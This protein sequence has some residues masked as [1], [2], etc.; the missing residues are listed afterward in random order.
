MNW[1]RQGAASNVMMG[2]FVDD[3]DGKTPET[4]LTIASAGGI[5][6]LA[7]GFSP[8][9]F[10]NGLNWYA[11]VWGNDD[12]EVDRVGGMALDVI[13]TAP[14]KAAHPPIVY[15]SGLL[16]VGPPGAVAG[17]S[18]SIAQYHYSRRRV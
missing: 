7:K 17:L 11:P 10:L 5:D 3:T 16:S 1:L 14:A 15:P 2:P 12:P 8:L 13:G 9:C 4:G 18:I 6:A